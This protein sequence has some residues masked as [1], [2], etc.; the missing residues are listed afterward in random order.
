[1][2]NKLSVRVLQFVISFATCDVSIILNM[3]VS[4][5]SFPSITFKT[6]LLVT[7]K[8]FQIQA[9]FSLSAN[10]KGL[11]QNFLKHL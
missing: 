9:P 3:F 1:M 11:L 4:L 8:C 10:P 2:R 5:N 7:L 6:M